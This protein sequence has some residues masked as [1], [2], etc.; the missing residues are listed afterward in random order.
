MELAFRSRP[1]TYASSA[2]GGKQ[3]TYG[4]IGDHGRGGGNLTE[5]KIIFHVHSMLASM[6]H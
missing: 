4:S 3:H 6:A 5:N 1:Q 2:E